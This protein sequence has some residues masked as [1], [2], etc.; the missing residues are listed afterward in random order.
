MNTYKAVINF[1]RRPSPEIKTLAGFIHET[2]S[3]NADVFDK[4]PVSLEDFQAQI[5]DFTAKI[6]ARAGNAK[7][8][9][10]AAQDARVAMLDTL[11]QLGNYVNIRAR[12]NLEVLILSGFPYYD[13]RR[14]RHRE[15]FSPP[16][17]PHRL[18][19]R[20]GAVS[21]MIL[22][23]FKTELPTAANIVQ[24]SLEGP[25]NE[26]VWQDRGIHYSHRLTLSDF[27]PGVL[28]YVRVRTIGRGGNLSDWS[29]VAQ[30]RTL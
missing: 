19:L 2:L 28:V 12:G 24:V 29:Q 4:P 3:A 6:L 21:G 5:T 13:T 15:P 23:R 10:V 1:A 27:P 9:V 17:P 11:R 20:H 18:V 7:V 26:A 16:M 8:D 30:I 22:L 25:H 14:V